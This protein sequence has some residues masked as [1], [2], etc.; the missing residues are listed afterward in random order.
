MFFI[1]PSRLIADHSLKF[2]SVFGMGYKYP[3][4][5][6]SIFGKVKSVMIFPFL[7]LTGIPLITRCLSNEVITLIL[8][9]L[10]FFS[11]IYT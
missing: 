10:P 11:R 7:S 2:A 1:L 6:F 5:T 3:F 9:L 8:H 4:F